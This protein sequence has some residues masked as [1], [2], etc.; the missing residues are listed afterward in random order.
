MLERI[1]EVLCEIQKQSELQNA[2]SVSYVQSLL[3]AMEY[4]ISYSSNELLEL[5]N[6]K[7]KEA[8]RKNY[9]NPALEQGLVEMTVPEKPRSKNQRYIKR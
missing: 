8:L 4:D 5:L 9:L 1:E 3:N 2:G 7:S 6:M